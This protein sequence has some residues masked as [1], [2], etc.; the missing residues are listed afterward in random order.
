MKTSLL[1]LLF[2]LIAAL[3]LAL[4]FLVPATKLMQ[5]AI[6]L[7]A[8]IAFVMVFGNPFGSFVQKVTPLLLG[9][10][11]MGLGA[12]MNLV[13]VARVGLYGIGYTVIG[14]S[15]ALLINRALGRL[16]KTPSDASLLIGGGTAICAGSAIASIAPVIHAKSHDIS[17]ALATIF[18]LNAVALVVFPKLGHL[19]GLDET[20][21]G[22]WCGLAIHDTS[23]VV[24]ASVQYGQHAL[25]VATT[26]KLARALWI[27][28]ITLIIAAVYSRKQKGEGPQRKTRKPWFILGFVIAAAIVT[29]I[30]A[31]H[32]AGLFVRGIAE[33]MIILALF[34]IGA[35]L[36]RSA[37]YT[38][39]VGPLLQGFCL[40]IVIASMTLAAIV[41]G[42]ITL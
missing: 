29:W 16:F 9:Y 8:G 37:F 6:S 27:I 14:I 18:I 38:M 30:P 7:V 32:H 31:F 26:V 15:L 24:G 34:F 33:H 2:C 5:P 41:S 11:V 20:Q 3:L 13:T 36:D 42:W 19:F 25:D 35:S 17:M 23:S 4:P 12:G 1:Q 22:L 28:P 39:G 21:F 10:A 40:W